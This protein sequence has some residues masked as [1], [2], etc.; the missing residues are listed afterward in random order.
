MPK[1]AYVTSL[2]KSSSQST[3]SD[4]EFSVDPAVF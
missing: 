1:Y 3:N 2:T 4:I